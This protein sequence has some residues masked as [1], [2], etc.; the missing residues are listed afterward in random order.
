[1][2][3]ESLE[4]WPR[5]FGLEDEMRRQTDPDLIGILFAL[6]AAIASLWWVC[7]DIV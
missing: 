4:K 1:M 7:R 2:R 5:S 3:F 6:V